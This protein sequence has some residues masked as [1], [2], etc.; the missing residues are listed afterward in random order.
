MAWKLGA[1]GM[2][3]VSSTFNIPAGH[4]WVISGVVIRPGAP[5]DIRLDAADG[6]DRDRRNTE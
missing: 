1:F 3:K 2:L 4:G 5:I 6:L